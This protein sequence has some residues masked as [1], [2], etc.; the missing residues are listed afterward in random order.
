LET[1]IFLIS[2]SRVL[3]DAVRIVFFQPMSSGFSKGWGLVDI[4][5]GLVGVDLAFWRKNAVFNPQE[6]TIG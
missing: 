6:L 5:F 3:D 2:I 4:R 1:G